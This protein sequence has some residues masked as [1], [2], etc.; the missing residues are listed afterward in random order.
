M[1]AKKEF[2]KGTAVKITAVFD[3]APD[4]VTITIENP[5][6]TDKV[7]DESMTAT[8]STVYTYIWQTEDSSSYEEGWHD[9]II[10]AV[11]GDYTSIN[12]ETFK[13]VDITE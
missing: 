7:D 4:S 5:F 9:A 1:S 3:E 12:Y 13:I 2:I 11:K 10:K 6:G 8:T